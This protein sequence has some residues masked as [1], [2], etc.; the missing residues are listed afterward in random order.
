MRKP[1]LGCVLKHLG[2]A[3]VL[4]EEIRNGY[5]SYRFLLYGHMDQAS[6]EAWGV[7]QQ[8]AKVIRQ[9]RV[10]FQYKPDYDIPFEAL[11]E[12]TVAVAELEDDPETA[13]ALVPPKACLVGLVLGESGMPVYDDDTRP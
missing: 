13:K 7:S 10:N 5:P 6:A 1:C 11:A 8:L 12:Y 3:A 2:A 4:E 9:H